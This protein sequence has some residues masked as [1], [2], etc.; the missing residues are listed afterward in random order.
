MITKIFPFID[1]T[2]NK[3]HWWAFIFTRVT[4]WSKWNI[5]TKYVRWNSWK[6]VGCLILIFY[7]QRFTLC[8][9]FQNNSL[10]VLQNKILKNKRPTGFHEFYLTYFSVYLLRVSLVGVRILFMFYCCV[11]IRS[12]YPSLPKML[13]NIRRPLWF[14]WETFSITLYLILV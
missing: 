5:W 6:P 9:Y 3:N 11:L 12:M 4:K 1:L 2:A 14:G 8:D 10:S 7:W 13:S